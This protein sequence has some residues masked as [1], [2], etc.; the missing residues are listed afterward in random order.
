MTTH[1]A[2]D[3]SASHDPATPADHGETHHQEVL[4]EEPKTPLWVTALGVALLVGGGLVYL[5]VHEPTVEAEPEGTA[6]PAISAEAPANV[7]PAE[8]PRERPKGLR[9][10]PPGASDG[11]PRR[12]PPN[13]RMLRPPSETP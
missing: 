7:V 9:M 11:P 3:D 13:L 6:E 4:P 10:A 2:H 12:L 5:V 1:D 8:P